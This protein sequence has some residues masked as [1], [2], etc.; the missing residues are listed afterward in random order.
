M[1]EQSRHVSLRSVSWDPETAA[2]AINEIVA[3]AVARFDEERFW[4]AHPLD[5]GIKDGHSSIYFGAAGVSL[6]SFMAAL[7]RTHNCRCA[8]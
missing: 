1:T 3:D 7:V 5:D 8:S 6:I 4:P 2:G